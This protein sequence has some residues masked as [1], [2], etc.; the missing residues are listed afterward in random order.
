L[1][2]VALALGLAA[3]ALFVL[4]PRRYAFALCGLAAVYFV[5][6]SVVVENG[7]HG[8]HQAAVGSLFAGIRVLHPD[9]I[10][11]AVGR[12]A[13]V[14]FVWHY[15]G[16]TRPLWNNEFFNRSVG[17]VYTVD[18]PD[19]A[20]GGLPETPVH[21]RRDGTL[22]TAGLDG[23]PPQVRYAVSYTDIAG[24]V[25]ARDRKLGLALY[26]VDGPLVVLTRV[27]GLYPN[28]TWSGRRLTYRR[29]RCTGGR[30][31][32]RLGTDEHLFTATQ[33]VTATSGG[34]VVGR[35]RIV[36][37]EQPTPTVPL[38]P[39]A[40]GTCTVTFT[41][42]S[43]RIPA[44]VQPGSGDTRPLGAHFFAFDVLP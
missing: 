9:W 14:V 36:P 20:D 25:L 18:G 31:A 12:D 29:L 38:R 16:E 4:V 30:L 40:H 8:I 1:R 11:R 13:S 41:M 5:G 33:L 2:I 44:R 24:D 19:P 42:A 26:R 6:S 39:D 21:E 23:T 27:R 3:A 28:D 43:L 22:V 7:R 15:A 37:G 35:Q 17:D 34:H 32:V 10:D